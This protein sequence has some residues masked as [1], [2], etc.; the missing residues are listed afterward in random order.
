MMY[1]IRF[2]LPTTDH[3]LKKLL[4]HFWEVVPKVDFS[5][6]HTRFYLSPNFQTNQDGKLLQEMILVCDAY[7][8]DLLHP[9]EYVRGSTLR[10]LCKLREPEL[11]EPLM[12]SI[13]KCLEHR[14]SYVRRNAILAIFTIY[15]QLCMTVILKQIEFQ[16]TLNF[17]FQMHQR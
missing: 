6:H 14:H 7:R 15:S 10:F 9:N 5:F 3:F 1:V 13:L 11:L 8:K 12:P 4:L 2:C 17:L 16:K